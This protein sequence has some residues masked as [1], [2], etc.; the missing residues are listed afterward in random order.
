MKYLIIKSKII[1]WEN[2]DDKRNKKQQG[3]EERHGRKLLELLGKQSRL[4]KV[5]K[6]ILYK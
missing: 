1:K 4:G 3:K 5:I 2:T 6:K